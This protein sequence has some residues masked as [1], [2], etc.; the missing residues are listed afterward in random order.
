MEIVLQNICFFSLLINTISYW[1]V[2][3]VSL[4]K[5]YTFILPAF[6]RLCLIL[7]SFLIILR[8]YFSGH[9][10][11]SN[12]Y[13]SLIFLAWTIQFFLIK[14]EN[15]NNKIFI[16]YVVFVHREHLNNLETN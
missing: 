14:F 7:L 3:G 13:E 6:N 15:K 10:P 2:I 8:W 4:L 5:K 12:L 16:F 9:F 11:L 1:L